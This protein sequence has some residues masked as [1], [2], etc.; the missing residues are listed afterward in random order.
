MRGGAFDTV[1]VDFRLDNLFVEQLYT[2]EDLENP[3]YANASILG[4]IPTP[5]PKSIS[6]SL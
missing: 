1:A 6:I 2:E 4:S 5:I 3:V